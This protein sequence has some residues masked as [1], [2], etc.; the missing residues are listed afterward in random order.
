MNL[1]SVYLDKIHLC[2]SIN[3]PKGKQISILLNKVEYF[4][5]L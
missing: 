1:I 5:I 2:S 4:F 3:K